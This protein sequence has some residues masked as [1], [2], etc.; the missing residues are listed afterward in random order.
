MVFPPFQNSGFAYLPVAD[1]HHRSMLFLPE[2]ES[3]QKQKWWCGLP[4]QPFHMSIRGKPGKF[5]FVF[6]KLFSHCW[7]YSIFCSTSPGGARLQCPRQ[8]GHWNPAR[9]PGLGNGSGSGMDST[10][11][12]RGELGLTGWPHL[13][14]SWKFE[15]WFRTN[16]FHDIRQV[17]IPP[18]PHHPS[19]L[20]SDSGGPL[21]LLPPPHAH[22]GG[23][24]CS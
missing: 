23:G 22:R 10:G 12:A 7:M 1:L 5:F 2:T 21:E 15:N 18:I 6:S 11:L 9:V 8:L 20:H 3:P 19:S 13:P 24:A 4:V 17:C 14:A 16:P